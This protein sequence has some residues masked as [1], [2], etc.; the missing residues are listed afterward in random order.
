ML[1][2]HSDRDAAMIEKGQDP[3]KNADQA[4]EEQEIH[5]EKGIEGTRRKKKMTAVSG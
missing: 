2:K 1:E 4:C 3:E 5:Y